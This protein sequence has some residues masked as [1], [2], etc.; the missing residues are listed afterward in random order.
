MRT[1]LSKGGDDLGVNFIF[2]IGE[3]HRSS[4]KEEKNEKSACWEN[5]GIDYDVTFHWSNFCKCCE[6]PIELKLATHWPAMH[7]MNNAMID[8]AR[9]IGLESGVDQGDLLSCRDAG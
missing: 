3:D 5:C 4:K 6:K 7:D 9:S 8:F 1:R 2:P